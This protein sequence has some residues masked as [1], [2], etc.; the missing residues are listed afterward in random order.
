MSNEQETQLAILLQV[1]KEIGGILVKLDN[2]DKRFDRIEEFQVETTKTLEKQKGA[3][4]Q[5]TKFWDRPEK[6]FT[7]QL[8]NII[9]FVIMLLLARALGWA[10]IVKP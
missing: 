5:K 3:S 9:T 7:N 6:V 4:E 1:Q 8:L 2:H 10:A